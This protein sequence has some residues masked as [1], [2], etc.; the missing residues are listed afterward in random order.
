[1]GLFRSLECCP[2]RLLDRVIARMK[3]IM[4]T[5]TTTPPPA[6]GPITVAADVALDDD[7]DDADALASVEFC[8]EL[9]FEDEEEV[10]D[11]DDVASIVVSGNLSTVV[12]MGVD[13]CE[14]DEIGEMVGVVPSVV[15]MGC[16]WLGGFVGVV[17]NVVGGSRLGVEN[18]DRDGV[19]I[20]CVI[21]GVVEGGAG[22]GT[23]EKRMK[24]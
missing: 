2:R 16:V 5:M 22:V 14:T 8:S 3:A 18:E 21:V 11:E 9:C 4:T 24:G 6:A 17:G 1:M 10:E 20:G 15:S 13:V 19:V 7:D 23:V 12:A